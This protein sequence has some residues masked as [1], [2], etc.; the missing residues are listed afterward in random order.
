MATIQ[1]FIASSSELVDDRKE[2]R[3]F[4]SIEND[5]LQKNGVYLELV[6]WENFLDAVSKTSLQD[7]YNIALKKSQ[8]VICL[9]YTR[10]GKYTQAEFDAALQQFKETGSPLIY[11]YF[12]SGAPKPDPAD[13]LAIDLVAFK[14]RLSDIG[15][16]YTSYDNM[17]DLK[18]QFRKQL[19]R[20]EDKGIIKVQQE[21]AEQTKEAV[22]NYFNIKN[23][24]TGNITAGGD[25][26]IGDKII[27]T[28]SANGNNNIII[29]GV[30]ESSITVNV[31]GQS[32]EIEKKLD[33]LQALMEQMAVKSVQSANAVYNIGNITDAN[34]GFLMGQAGHNQFL[35]AS[36]SDNLVGEGDEWIKGLGKALLKQGIP[37]GDDSMEIFQN[38]D[39]LIQAFLQKMCSPPGQ[40][41]TLRR[42]S[43]MAETYQASLR[44]LCYIQMSQVLQM[45]NKAKLGI[46]SDFIQME[47]DKYVDFDYSGLLLTSTGLLGST[48]FVTEIGKFV[49]ELKDTGSDLFGTAFFLETQRR[50]LLAGTIAEDDKFQLL[51]D[52]YLTALVYWLKQ[53][54]FLANYRLVSIKDINLNFRLGAEETYLHRYGEL[55]SMYNEGGVAD[56][57]KSI[58]IRKSFTFSKS[59]LLFKGNVLAACLKNI[60]DKNSYLSLSPL[61][62]DKSV[63][64]NDNNKQTPEIFYYAGYEKP[65]RQYNYSPINKE[66]ALGKTVDNARYPT[67]NIKAT[68]TEL[69]GLDDLFEQLED[70]F[71][72]FKIKQS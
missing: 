45:E 63:Y 58:E 30:T 34:F 26:N 33:V 14:K 11:T 70:I 5:R 36:L 10:A 18:Y 35:P 6:Q 54:S 59:I 9:F 51:L 47:G 32:K 1:I 39:W 12:K 3:E 69:S 61:L 20:L 52:E 24:V 49:N 15:H 42:L 48:G 43:F 22:T 29:Q 38:Y 60:Q 55:H 17:A 57:T 23:V 16:F 44:Y 19:D 28:A 7:E 27:N 31:N 71:K 53:I 2:F 40:E 66:L 4:L 56:K 25:V 41:K 21:V 64:A 37:V 8:I 62:I 72:P 65:N 46:I 67:L 68:N 50:N 13:Q